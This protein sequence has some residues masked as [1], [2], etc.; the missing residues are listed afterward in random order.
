MKRMVIFDMDGTL[1]DVR[2]ARPLVDP[3]VP[4]GTVVDVHG[5]E[6]TKRTVKDFDAFHLSSEFCPP[7]DWV[8]EEAQKSHQMGYVNG[9]LTGRMEQYRDLTSRYLKKYETPFR[10]LLMRPQDD[11]RKDVEIKA[12]K[13]HLLK[14][15]GYQFVRAFDDNPNIIALWEENGIPV[16]VVPGWIGS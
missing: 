11:F 16:T 14:D 7:Y 1:C 9:I 3:S 8:V 4:V 13:L 12:E 2:A 15:A 10:W 6:F 5:V